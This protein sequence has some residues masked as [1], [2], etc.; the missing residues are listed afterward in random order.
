MRRSPRITALVA[1]V[2]STA[3][4]TA[5]QDTAIHDPT[6]QPSSAS[7]ST[8]EGDSAPVK[9]AGDVGPDGADAG[10]REH[11][12]DHGGYVVQGSRITFVYRNG[13]RHAV[14]VGQQIVDRDSTVR[15]SKGVLTLKSGT[16]TFTD[17]RGV[18]T[19]NRQGAGAVADKSGAIV[20]A[21]DGS[22]TCANNRGLQFVGS[23]GTK[24][25]ADQDGVFYTNKDGKTVT[26]GS[27]PKVNDL[28]GR[29]TVCN[30]GNTASVDLYSDVLFTFN[31]AT[32]TPAGRA[33]ISSAARSIRADVKGKPVNL[34]G[35]TDSKGTA[36]YN[37]SLGKR[38]ADAVAGQLR[39]EIPGLDL[40][41]RSAGETEPVAANV[42]TDGKDNPGGR[43]KNRRV[44]I[45]WQK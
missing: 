2:A 22:T 4:L 44:T 41:V 29:F 1:A 7:A 45:A 10:R 40:K 36:G 31:K 32:L 17:R 15:T 30:I 23:K 13:M 25:A 18:T 9:N 19:V 8:S 42:T 5:C 24:A 11:L 6:G 35:H 12:S 33:V 21:E 14:D 38:R 43:A 27:S 37:K 34:T 26:R 39:R 28:A 16:A 20:V 3:A